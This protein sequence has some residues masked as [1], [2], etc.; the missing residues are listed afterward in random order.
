MTFL[1]VISFFLLFFKS[2]KTGNDIFQVFAHGQHSTGAV[3]PEV[4]TLAGAG[5]FTYRAVVHF[6]SLIL[7][8]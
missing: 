7:L 1:H 8:L 6:H 2:V 4:A 3:D 5:L